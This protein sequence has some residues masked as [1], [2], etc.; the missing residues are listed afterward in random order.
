MI[1]NIIFDFDGVILDSVPIKTEGF[2]KLFEKFPINK[3]EKLIKYHKINGGKSRYIKIKYFFNE[4]LNEN[5][6]N[7]EVLEYSKQ[8]SQ[9]TKEELSNS[10]YIIEE[11]IHFIKNNYGKYKMHIASGAD[12]SIAPYKFS[13]ELSPI[14]NLGII[15]NF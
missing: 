6:S 13:S 1:K 3:V 4:L 10:K 14:V 15:Y 12:E 11:T 5:I 2:K 8:Y 9:I 7:D